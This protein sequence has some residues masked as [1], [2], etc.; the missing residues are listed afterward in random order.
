VPDEPIF[1]ENNV[2]QSCRIEKKK[3]VKRSAQR[4]KP[5]GFRFIGRRFFFE[6]LSTFCS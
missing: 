6:T 3:P 1:I 2:S 5:F 4:Q